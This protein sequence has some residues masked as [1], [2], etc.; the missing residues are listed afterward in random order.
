MTHPKRREAAERLASTAPPGAL[1]V[2]MDP[3]PTGTPSVLRTALAAWSS[4]EDGAT[5]QLVVQDDMVLSDSFFERARRAVEAMPGAALALFALW[6]SRNGAAVR[7]GALAGARWVGAVNE[8]FPCVSI[9]LP[10]QVAEGFVAYGRSRLGGWPD[11]ILMYRYLTEQCIPRYVS[12][13]NLAEHQDRGSISGNAFRGPRRSVSFL[14]SDPAG[15]EDTRLTG[16]TV[17]PFFKQ[18]VAQC[19]VRVAGP[20]PQ[21]WLHLDCERYL[22]G[23]GVPAA[24]L[25]TAPPAAGDGDRGTW[26]TAF[27]TGL[28]ERRDGLRGTSGGATASPDPAVVAEALATIGP[29]G[30]SHA[31]TEE[32]IEERRAELARTAREGLAAGREAAEDLARPRRNRRTSPSRPRRVGVIGA[33]TPLGEHIV[34]GLADRGHPVTVLGPWGPDEDGCAA[35]ADLRGLQEERDGETRLSVNVRTDGDGRPLPHPV[36]YTLH[37][38]DL[39][40]PGCSRHTPIGR[41]V[42][43]ALR[44][45]PV[46]LGTAPE[47]PLHPLHVDDLTDALGRVLGTPPAAR[48]LTLADPQPCTAAGLAEAVCG[49]VRPVPVEADGAAAGAPVRAVL[50]PGARLP[51][52]SPATGLGRGLHSFAQWLAYEGIR[53]MAD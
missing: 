20:G 25:R 8:Y 49:A 37:A 41:M 26:L 2:V 1:R 48:V 46:V 35:V 42:W 18:G 28:V 12:V 32:Q 33:A 50:R 27:A 47:R 6:D 21:R 15:H 5:H 16:L 17:V 7:F 45:H 14:P 10:R 36:T 22:A 31:R 13:P 34:R 19:A 52:W 3:D 40:G 53:L 9:I 4:I 29:G 23:A 38:G 44:S 43:N 11:D 24:R 30:I 51:G 39:Y